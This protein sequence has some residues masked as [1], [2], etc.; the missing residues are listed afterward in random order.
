MVCLEIRFFHLNG[1]QNPNRIWHNA[2][3]GLVPLS[4]SR[5]YE[6]K[7]AERFSCIVGGTVHATPLN[8]RSN[9]EEREMSIFGEQLVYVNA[10]V[11]ESLK[12]ASEPRGASSRADMHRALVEYWG[13]LKQELESRQDVTMRTHAMLAYMWTNAAL[14]KDISYPG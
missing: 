3:P 10:G 9:N 1:L 5:R 2:F 7:F 13:S 4:S 6:M 11:V 8:A 12:S 14:R